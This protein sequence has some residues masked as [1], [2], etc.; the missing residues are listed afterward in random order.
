MADGAEYA[1]LPSKV[2]EAGGELSGGDLPKTVSVL[3]E[4]RF[5]AASRHND[6]VTSLSKPTTIHA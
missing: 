6:T 4:E 5:T 3:S 2:K 1:W